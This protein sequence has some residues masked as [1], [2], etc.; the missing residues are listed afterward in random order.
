[1]TADKHKRGTGASSSSSILRIHPGPHRSDSVGSSAIFTLC[2]PP[3]DLCH[4]TRSR[5]RRIFQRSDSAGLV[6]PN[7]NFA[8]PARPC[9][10]GDLY[11]ANVRL[12]LPSQDSTLGSTA[13][14]HHPST[15]NFVRCQRTAPTLPQPPLPTHESRGKFYKSFS[16]LPLRRRTGHTAILSKSRS[17]IISVWNST[18]PK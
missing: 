12:P 15:I 14:N 3:S 10:S 13:I 2:R 9:C 6:Q 8:R 17:R 18:V 5:I 4:L 11:E 1:M 16:Q 7:F